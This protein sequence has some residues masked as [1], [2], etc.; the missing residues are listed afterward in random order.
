MMASLLYSQ[1]EV[2]QIKSNESIS[3]PNTT[4]YYNIKYHWPLNKSNIITTAQF[5]KLGSNYRV[6]AKYID[7]GLGAGHWWKRWSSDPDVQCLPP[8]V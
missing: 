2:N 5:K 6:C 3:C 7:K 1:G 8:A 4:T